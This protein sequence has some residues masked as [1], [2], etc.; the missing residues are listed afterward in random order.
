MED[1]I[2]KMKCSNCDDVPTGKIEKDENGW[3][4]LPEK[5]EKCN[6][7]LVFEGEEK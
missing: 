7:R 3:L 6:S 1:R 4:L 5:C 2:I